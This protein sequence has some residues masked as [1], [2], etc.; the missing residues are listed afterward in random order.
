[1]RNQ[2]EF[3][4]VYKNSHRNHT[5]YL[6]DKKYSIKLS[7]NEVWNKPKMN[8]SINKIINPS[9]QLYGFSK[10]GDQIYKIENSNQ[11]FI[12]RND[13]LFLF[14]YLDKNEKGFDEW[15]DEQIGK[16]FIRNK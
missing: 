9:K 11:C 6:S 12:K 4:I 5:L 7:E 3:Y 2:S 8:D 16:F 14:N 13:T 10:I 1:M 15:N